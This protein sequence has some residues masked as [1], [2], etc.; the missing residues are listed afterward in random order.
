MDSELLNLFF[1]AAL[2]STAMGGITQIGLVVL[3]YPSLPGSLWLAM[4]LD[5]AIGL[6]KLNRQAKDIT[7]FGLLVLFIT[8]YKI[9]GLRSLGFLAAMAFT[10]QALP[11]IFRAL[12]EFNKRINR[13]M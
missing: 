3:D 4:R 2:A 13:L 1:V 9:A 5:R 7:L 11:L 6:D 10:F 8:G 12:C